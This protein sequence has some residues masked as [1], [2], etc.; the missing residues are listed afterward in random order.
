[1]AQVKEKK[2][3]LTEPSNRASVPSVGRAVL[4]KSEIPWSRSSG[5]SSGGGGSMWRSACAV[6]DCCAGWPSVV[7]WN[8]E[9]QYNVQKH[10][11]GLCYAS[12]T[13]VAASCYLRKKGLVQ[14]WMLVKRWVLLQIREIRRQ[15]VRPLWRCSSAGRGASHFDTF[16]NTAVEWKSLS[17][18]IGTKVDL[19]RIKVR[20]RP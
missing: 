12:T 19:P 4:E 9:K 16:L 18:A 8:K 7:L 14:F 15:A 6:L 17:H 11:W 13:W 5:G 20:V 10:I 1:M 3:A 2:L